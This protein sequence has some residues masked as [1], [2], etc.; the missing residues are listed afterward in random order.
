MDLPSKYWKFFL[1][2]LVLTLFLSMVYTASAQDKEKKDGKYLTVGASAYCHFGKPPCTKGAYKGKTAS[3]IQVRRGVIA[4]DPKYIKLGSVVEILE[5]KSYAGYYIAA[6]TGG[7]RIK[8]LFI[9][10][11]VSTYK[12]ARAFGLKK[13]VL[14]RVL[15]KEEAEAMKKEILGID[16]KKERS[17]DDE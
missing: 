10:V 2:F 14:L 17:K 6:D 13:N 7:P 1:C 5:P 15:P 16:V 3:G 11:W 12:E 9:D 8:K 4:V